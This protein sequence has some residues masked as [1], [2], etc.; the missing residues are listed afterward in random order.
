MA[1]KAQIFHYLVI[2]YLIYFDYIELAS[3]K[4]ER[5]EISLDQYQAGNLESNNTHRY[6]SNPDESIKQDET[7]STVRYDSGSNSTQSTTSSVSTITATATATTSTT[8]STTVDPNSDIEDQIIPLSTPPN[9]QPETASPPT[10]TSNKGPNDETVNKSIPSIG[11]TNNYITQD[12]VE[13][14]VLFFSIFVVYVSFV[15]LIYHNVALIKHNMT[16]PG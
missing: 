16:E 2:Y 5:I 3:F 7:T 4:P 12:S 10:P 11:H 1:K 14:N 13:L 8:T 15:K 6:Y 9:G